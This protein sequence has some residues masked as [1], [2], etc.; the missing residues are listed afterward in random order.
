[1]KRISKC[2]YCHHKCHV[3]LHRQKRLARGASLISKPRS[4]HEIQAEDLAFQEVDEDNPIDEQLEEDNDVDEDDNA[5]ED[6]ED[7]TQVN[8]FHLN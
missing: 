4:V 1:M 6:E 7:D 5:D 3:Q 2:W 8:L